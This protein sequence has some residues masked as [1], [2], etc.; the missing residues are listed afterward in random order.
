M[1]VSVMEELIILAI[2]FIDTTFTGADPQD[3][4][5]ILINGLDVVAADAMRVARIVLVVRELLS[6]RIKPIEAAAPCTNPK[7]TCMILEDA[8]N[9]VVAQ[10]VRILRV[11]SVDREAVAVVLVQPVLCAEPHVSL[12]ILQD[13][14]YRALRQPLLDR[15]TVKPDVIVPGTLIAGECY[16]DDVSV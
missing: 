4:N 5:T 3:A 1:A 9:V 14:R 6:L 16:A 10:A 7:G 13:A 11:M 15:D 2:E 12:V 8:A